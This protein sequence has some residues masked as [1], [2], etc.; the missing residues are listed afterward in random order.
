MITGI[1]RAIILDVKNTEQKPLLK[2][3]PVLKDLKFIKTVP[4]GDSPKTVIISP[5]GRLAAVTN[6]EDSS[7][8]LFDTSTK[9]LLRKITFKRSLYAVFDA[10]TGEKKYYY[11]QKPVEGTFDHTGRYLWVGLYGSGGVIRYDMQEQTNT[12][13]ETKIYEE[14]VVEDLEKNKKYSI[15]LPLIKTGETPKMIEEMPNKKYLLV[16]NWDSGTVSVID[17]YNLK[18]IK[19]IKLSPHFNPVPRGIAYR[20]DSREAYVVNQGGG[21]ISV[22]DL[23][24]LTVK[25]N[26]PVASNPGHIIISKDDRYLFA[27]YLAGRKVQKIEIATGKVVKNIDFPYTAWKINITPDEK[28]II[29]GFRE[30]NLLCILDEKTFS[31]VKWVKNVMSPMGIGITPDSKQLWIVGQLHNILTLY[32]LIWD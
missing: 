1:S 19:N 12:I 8:W 22:L 25:R 17:H 4:L 18:N 26:I 28:Y 21:F 32:D 31:P 6:L 14:A 23:E 7:I 15:K 24:N 11:Q 9:N 20:S 3:E 30:D 16:S 10:E 27:A 5:D 2:K 29:V 13:P